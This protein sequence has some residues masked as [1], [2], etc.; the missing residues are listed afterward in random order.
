MLSSQT[1]TSLM[2]SQCTY[3]MACPHF[4]FILSAI[5][6]AII[7]A[8][9]PSWVYHLH[10]LLITT[11]PFML[12]FL[13]GSCFWLILSTLSVTLNYVKQYN[14]SRQESHHNRNNQ[15][16]QVKTTHLNGQPSSVICCIKYIHLISPQ[17]CSS[18]LHLVNTIF[19]IPIHHGDTINTPSLQTY[20]W[21][22]NQ[23]YC[24]CHWIN[25]SLL[26]PLFY[27]RHNAQQPAPFTPNNNL[28]AIICHH[29]TSNS[30]CSMSTPLSTLLCQAQCPV[31]RTSSQPS[32]F[33]ASC[34]I[35][36][37]V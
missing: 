25:P 32:I 27:A 6:S 21:T 17:P 5:I 2:P 3:P 24:H 14:S 9:A 12:S 36:N 19:L 20:Q 7:P 30:D 34:W 1:E 26:S 15:A 31:P 4:L 13:V 10:L 29:L 23:A 8:A 11:K 37:P 35:K 16:W 33:R 28:S 18:H 22:S